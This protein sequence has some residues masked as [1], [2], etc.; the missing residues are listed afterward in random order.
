MTESKDT[1]STEVKAGII[2]KHLKEKLGALRDGTSKSTR[3]LMVSMQGPQG[4]GKHNSGESRL[5]SGKSTLAAG[6]VSLLANWGLKCAV[7]SLD[8]E[9]DN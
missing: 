2:A 9:V 1:S 6:L 5:I 8:G 3:P 4:A 7:A